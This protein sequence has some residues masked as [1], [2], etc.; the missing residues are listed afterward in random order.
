ML[1]LSIQVAIRLLSG[2]MYQ[3]MVGNTTKILKRMTSILKQHML[4]QEWSLR[5]MHGPY[6]GGHMLTQSKL[7]R[8][9]FVNI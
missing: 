4:R 3:C 8:Q 1:L 6:F 5:F 9:Y 2:S 7:R